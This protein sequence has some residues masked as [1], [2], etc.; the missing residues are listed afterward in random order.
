MK[1]SKFIGI[2]VLLLS[3]SFAQICDTLSFSNNTLSCV[4]SSSKT[5]SQ[6]ELFNELSQH[7]DYAQANL[8]VLEIEA[9]LTFSSDLWQTPKDVGIKILEN[10]K[11]KCNKT[12]T[13]ILA[14]K[15]FTGEMS[16]KEMPYRIKAEC[17]ETTSTVPKKVYID[18]NNIPFPR[19][20]IGACGQVLPAK[21][22]WETAKYVNWKC[23]KP[24]GST[25]RWDPYT[26][27]TEFEIENYTGD[28]GKDSF[29]N[30]L[31]CKKLK[32]T[33][34]TEY[35]QIFP[36]VIDGRFEFRVNEEF[37]IKNASAYYI[38][39]LNAEKVEILNSRIVLSSPL[40]DKK[41]SDNFMN[42]KQYIRIENSS[43]DLQGFAGR[44]KGKRHF[45]VSEGAK[46]NENNGYDIYVENS[47]FLAVQEGNIDLFGW[48]VEL[49]LYA[50]GN[51]N[52][53]FSNNKIYNEHPYGTIEIITCSLEGNNNEI[54]VE[55]NR[56]TLKT[57][58]ETHKSKFIMKKGSLSWQYNLECGACKRVETSGNIYKCY[59][60]SGVEIEY[61]LLTEVFNEAANYAILELIMKDEENYMLGLIKKGAYAGELKIIAKNSS[62]SFEKEINVDSIELENSEFNV[63]DDIK[64]EDHLCMVDSLLEFTGGQKTTLEISENGGK[65]TCFGN[66]ERYAIYIKGGKRVRYALDERADPDKSHYA[67]VSLATMD[68]GGII[69]AKRTDLVINNKS[70]MPMK[71]EDTWFVG[72]YAHR[73]E[74]GRHFIRFFGGDFTIYSCEFEATNLHI[75]PYEKLKF[76]AGTADDEQKIIFEK[77]WGNPVYEFSVDPS[78]MIPAEREAMETL[79]S[80]SGFILDKQTGLPVS[81]TFSFEVIDL[82]INE[83]GCKLS[84]ISFSSGLI[85]Y[86]L[87]AHAGESCILIPQKQH[88]AK[89]TINADGKVDVFEVKFRS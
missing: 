85:N 52:L 1:Y 30:L 38:E 84:N 77:L 44:I 49:Q 25:S 59:L 62:G 79:L 10:G 88:T 43:I 54:W 47:E 19:D 21:C 37:Y 11:L 13:C 86:V 4:I 24:A 48:G 68:L 73:V 17:I 63:K 6:T 2:M 42:A 7:A 14:I 27:C 18:K 78:C 64:L 31:Y 28:L 46:G 66:N 80:I 81:G 35:K 33:Q 71:L 83:S 20:V 9:E 34:V 56:F 8:V 89:I 55:G 29:G 36:A 3:L 70:K 45:V 60:P 65:T 74:N 53:Y 41:T 61:G 58:E 51:K 69:S 12:S 32:L 15:Y 23:A 39:N 75:A 16:K 57:N 22:T 67:D 26:G 87:G 40:G 76:Y 50:N 5:I 72:A 82:G